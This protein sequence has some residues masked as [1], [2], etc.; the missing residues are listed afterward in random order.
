MIDLANIIGFKET[1]IE[2]KT[3]KNTFPRLKEAIDDGQRVIAGALDTYY[4]H[5]YPNL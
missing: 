1:V 3:L 5:Y 4:L 2:G